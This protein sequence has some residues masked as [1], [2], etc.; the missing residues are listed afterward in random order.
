[1]TQANQYPN[2]CFTFNYGGDDQPPVEACERF[3]NDT[4]PPLAGYFI[5]GYEVASTGQKHVQ[6]YVQFIKR[7]R[8]TALKKLPDAG[9]IHWEPAKG[10]EVQNREYCTKECGDN[11]VE[12]GEA[13]QINPGGRERERWKLAR[14][15]C[16]AGRIEDVDDQIFICHYGALRCIARDYSVSM[17]DLDDV[18]GVWYYGPSGTGKSRTARATYGGGTD[19]LYLKPVNKWWDGFR[20]GV[21]ENVLLEDVEPSHSVLGYHL[22]IWADRYSFPAETKGSTIQIRPKKVIVT[23]QYHPSLIFQDPEALAAIL[24]RYVLI[25]VQSVVDLKPTDALCATVGSVSHVKAEI[26]SSVTRAGVYSECE[27]HLSEAEDSSLPSVP[28]KRSQS[29]PMSPLPPSIQKDCDSEGA[30][31]G[32]S[33][34]RRLPK[35]RKGSA[36]PPQDSGDLSE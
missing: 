15:A 7:Q 4:L 24:R 9:T 36:P 2:W 18:C 11:F 8:L 35:R 33:K 25:H 17:P 22:K 30:S 34:S 5:A 26:R 23:S 3:L 1:M 6:G 16:V 10:D 14:A 28:L 32:C 31:P 27:T 20:Q 19:K 12:F 29:V 21:H 13:K